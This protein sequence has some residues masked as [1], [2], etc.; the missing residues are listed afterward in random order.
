M[1]PQHLSEERC[2]H[3]IVLRVGLL[4]HQR[5]WRRADFI[6]KSPAEFRC[7]SGVTGTNFRQPFFQQAADTGADHA[8]GHQAL[9]DP[10]ER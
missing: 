10:V 3:F 2:R 8:V 9:L 7:G 4:R 1:P 5:D 6:D